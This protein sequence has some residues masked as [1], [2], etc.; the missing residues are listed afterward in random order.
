MLQYVYRCWPGYRSRYS[1]SLPAGRF[2]VRITLEEIF[3]AP[4]QTG[5]GS[6]PASSVMCAEIFPEVKRQGRGVGHHL[7]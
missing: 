2:G 7:I 5:P 1:D 4:V 3:F 6:H